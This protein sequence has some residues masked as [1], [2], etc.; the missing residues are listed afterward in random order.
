MLQPRNRQVSLDNTPSTTASPDVCC[1]RS[2]LGNMNILEK[3]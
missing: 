1:E 3:G 2:C